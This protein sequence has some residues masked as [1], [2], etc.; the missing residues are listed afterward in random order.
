MTVKTIVFCDICNSKAIRLMDE[1]RCNERES[2]LGGRR[3]SDGRHWFEGSV[4][5]ALGAGWVKDR[6]GR[7]IC[8][9][10]HDFMEMDG[11][12]RAS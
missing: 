11:R 5:D 1:R 9:R 12:A 8:S 2:E 4:S 10:C 3:I 7:H 6:S